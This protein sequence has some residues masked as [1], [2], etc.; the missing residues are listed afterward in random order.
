[1]KAPNFKKKEGRLQR[2]LIL[3]NL[4]K[5][6]MVITPDEVEFFRAYPDEL[7]KMTSSL[8]AKKVYLFFA[9]LLGLALV[10][11][12]VILRYYPLLFGMD[13]LLHAFIIDLTFEGGVSLWGAG[14]TVYLLEV[15]LDNQNKINE[16]YREAVLDE[17]R[18]KDDRDVN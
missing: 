14:I 18:K 6:A 11:V 2:K 12:S 13:T 15:V 10:A 16:E 4:R 17:I 7:E 5:R 8:R 9:A 3:K 1:M